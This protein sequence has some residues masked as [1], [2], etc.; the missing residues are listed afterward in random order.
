MTSITTIIADAVAEERQAFTASIL[1]LAP[2]SA[3]PFARIRLSLGDCAI[4]F[5]SNEPAFL[6]SLA[7]NLSTTAEELEKAQRFTSKETR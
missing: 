5:S 2:W 1:G 4:S 3:P 7:D 6:R